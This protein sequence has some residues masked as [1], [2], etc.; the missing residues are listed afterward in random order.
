M[1]IYTYSEARRHLAG[2]LDEARTEE[3]VITRKDGRRFR[4]VPLA[5]AE[6]QSPFD[7]EGVDCGTDTAEILAVLREGR[8]RGG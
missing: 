6:P 1:R 3:V 4:I 2:L 5:V 7:I 8:A